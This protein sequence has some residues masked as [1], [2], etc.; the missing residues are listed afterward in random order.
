MAGDGSKYD[1]TFAPHKVDFHCDRHGI[2]VH[3]EV[4]VPPDDS[5]EIRRV[6][7][8]NQGDE[9]RRLRLVSYGELVLAQQNTD[10]R[11]PAFNKMFIESDYDAEHDALLFTRRPRAQTE[12]PPV[13]GHAVV[14][15][16]GEAQRSGYE[17]DRER[18]LGRGGSIDA[19]AALAQGTAGLTGT[20]GAVLDPI[21]SLSVEIELPPHTS[22]GVGFLTSAG[23]D[24]AEVLSLIEKYQSWDH[25][26]RAFRLAEAQSEVEMR[27]LEIGT[28]H[29][30]RFQ[31]LLSALL[32]PHQ[33]L[34]ADIELLAANRQGQ[35]NLWPYAISGDYP[36][37]LARIHSEEELSLVRELLQAHTYWRNRGLQ[38]DL[39]LLNQEDIGY[40]QELQ[41]QMRRMVERMN[42]DHWINRRGGIFLLQRGTMSAADYTLISTAARAIVDG[43]QGT[44]AAQLP[45]VAQQPQR[46]PAFFASRDTADQPQL[47]PPARPQD[48]RF[49]NGWGG[50]SPDGREYVIYLEPG[51]QPPAP[52]TNVIANPSFGFLVTASGGGNTWAMNSGENRLTPWHNDPV[53]DR[54]GEVLYLRDEETGAVWSPTPDPLGAETPHLIRHGAGYTIFESHSHGLKQKMRLFTP[55]DA[56][57]KIIRLSLENQWDRVRRITAT[58][59]AEW[60]LGVD[61]DLMQQYVQPEYDRAA[62]VLL[63]RNPYNAEF[64]QRVAFL[65]STEEPH[66]LTTDRTEFLGRLGSLRSPAA[67]RRVGLAGTVQPGLDPCAALQLHVDL[68]PGASTEITFLLGQGADRAEAVELAQ[69]FQDAEQVEAAWQQTRRH[70]D[71]MLDRV[72]VETPDEAMNIV[73]NRW[74]PYQ[75]AACRIWG[76]SAFYQSSGAFGFRDQL[77]DVAALL[78]HAPEVAREHI[79]R[80]A[81]HQFEAGDV[82]HW[83]HPPSGRGVRTRISDDLLWLPYITA[84]YVSVTGDAA[85]LQEQIAFRQGEPLH[86]DEEERYNQ[87]ELS[88]ARYSLYE[89]CCRA[90]AK[91]ATAGR[92]GLP[93]IGAGDWNDGMNRVGIEGE[94]ESVWLGWFLYATLENFLPLCTQMDDVDRCTQYRQKM[95]DLREALDAHAWDGKWY[96]RGFY[97][98][99]TPLGSAESLECRIDSIAQSW[100]ILSGAGRPER[101]RQ[102]MDA[103]SENLVRRD[104]QLLQLFT[105]AFDKTPRDPGYIKGYPPGIRENGGQYTHAA[106]WSVWA[107]AALGDGDRAGELFR[108]LNPILHGD[109]QAKTERYRIEPYVIAADVYSVPP[110]VG[111]GGW[112]WYTGSGGWFYRLGTEAILGLRRQGDVLRIEPCIPRDW[113]EYCLTYRFGQATYHIRVENRSGVNRGVQ[114]VT[115]D[116]EMQPEKTVPLKDDGEHHT[117][118]VRM[119]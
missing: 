56:P 9:P 7:L 44:L 99:G 90:I 54:P 50:F 87:Y 59:Y 82:L 110:F 117:V 8:T 96:L 25:V 104:D 119:G 24:R 4:T 32:Y 78:L 52:W 77:Q 47:P 75:N 93:L 37:L 69:R 51:R 41:G 114:Q 5:L 72:S 81:Q 48:L 107:F 98:D 30:R 73:L 109:T 108:L 84:H 101:A 105:P 38:I 57:I 10:R 18:F 12:T 62:N 15:E 64:G 45:D 79:L 97:D 17:T 89:H 115:V 40:N 21:L 70:W 106:I 13:L 39:V 95:D 55:P 63:A 92:H 118:R 61:R 74:L 60:V 94:G 1:I 34:R 26:D 23:A 111:R 22:V 80:A 66:G 53:L 67:L 35:A 102:A 27:Q 71:E 88:D 83:W 91:G 20:T 46:L 58:Y 76:R 36:I 100:A 116:G 86:Q 33:S 6:R 49:D 2:V 68:G 28:E 31:Q 29:L 14:V 42:S 85:I 3:T 43:K 19:P 11:H 112:S 113:P 103:V 65:A 16:S